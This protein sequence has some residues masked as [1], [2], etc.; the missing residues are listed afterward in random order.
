MSQIYDIVL[1]DDSAQEVKEF[2]V[3]R[4]EVF[5]RLG[6][7]PPQMLRLGQPRKISGI[8]NKTDDK[9]LTYDPKFSANNGNKIESLKV[10]TSHYVGTYEVETSKWGLARVDIKPRFGN[11][12]FNYLLSHVS[13]VFIP[14]KATSSISMSSNSYGH[15][16]LLLLWKAAFDR[17]LT[18]NHIPRCYVARER[19]MKTVRGRVLSEHNIREN[20]IDQSRIYCKYRELAF[21][22]IINKTIRYSYRLL[23]KHGNS[24]FLQDV[25]VYDT[26]LASLGVSDGIVDSEQIRNITYTPMN[27]SYRLLMEVSQKVIANFGATAVGNRP[28]FKGMSF[29]LDVA[30]LWENYIYRLLKRHFS[31]KFLVVS[32]NF[33]GERHYLLKGQWREIRP[34]ILMIRNGKIEAVLDAKYKSGYCQ[35]GA[36]EIQGVSVSREDLYQMTTYLWNLRQPDQGQAS[37]MGLFVSPKEVDDQSSSTTPE[38][39]AFVSNED[40][41]IGLINLCLPKEHSEDQDKEGEKEILAK[42]KQFEKQFCENVQKLLCPVI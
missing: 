21:D 32:P 13:G 40:V 42:A 16:L 1:K 31:D 5:D 3:V 17:A 9:I 23:R 24:S 8:K 36:T 7:D 18:V 20:W 27:S 29:F 6:N 22:N 10:V 39:R 11:S 2:L 37:I 14:P 35:L 4:R 12:I 38:L 28:R 15:W 26:K 19:N 41:S 25:S 30:E 34:D 33:E